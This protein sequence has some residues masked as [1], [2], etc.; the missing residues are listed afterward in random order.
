MRQGDPAPAAAV[1]YGGVVGEL[2][3]IPERDDCTTRLKED[4]VGIGLGV[5]LPSELLIELPRTCEGR[6]PPT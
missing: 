2:V 5:R 6:S 4:D 1:A 3:P